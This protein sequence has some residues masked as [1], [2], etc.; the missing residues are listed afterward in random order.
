MSIP[1]A[2]GTAGSPGKVMMSPVS[3]TM[4]PAPLQRRIVATLTVNPVGLPS[5]FGSSDKEYWVF[6][7][8][9]GRFPLPSA[10]IYLIA[11]SA[12]AE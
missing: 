11:D 8:Q 1:Q 10:S 6:A 4:N 9:I 12:A 5:L 3:A 7:T 2:A